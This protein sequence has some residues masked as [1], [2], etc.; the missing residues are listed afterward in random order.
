MCAVCVC[1]EA[2]AGQPSVSEHLGAVGGGLPGATG[3]LA[4]LPCP[5]TPVPHHL[6]PSVSEPPAGQLP[7]VGDERGR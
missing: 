5:A 6:T 7:Q 1:S 2:G 3:L 4:S